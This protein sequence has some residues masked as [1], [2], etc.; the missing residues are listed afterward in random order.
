[1]KITRLRVVR[2]R[3]IEALDTRTVFK[4]DAIPAKGMIIRGANGGGKSSVL[5]AIRAAL[6]GQDIAADAIRLGADRADILLDLDDFTVKRAITAKGS[7]LSIDGADAALIRSPADWLATMIGAAAFDPIDLFKKKPKDR[8]AA[9]LGAIP[10]RVTAEELT[11]WLEGWVL[12]TPPDLGV[13]ALDVVEAARKDFY[14]RRGAENAKA[15]EIQREIDALVAGAPP[16]VPGALSQDEARARHAADYKAHGELVARRKRVEEHTA[17]TTRTRE[18]VAKLRATAA[19]ARAVAG[20]VDRS[21]ELAAEAAKAQ[22]EV[23]RIREKLQV[24]HDRE[25]NA[26]LATNRIGDERK[27]NEAALKA[28]AA[29]L[30]VVKAN[31]DQAA[32]LDAAVAAT[33]ETSPTD[34]EIAASHAAT[35]ESSHEVAKAT[36]AELRAEH[37]A[38][39]AET[40]RRLAGAHEAAGKLDAMVS[41]FTK[42]VPTELL[43]K[44]EGLRGLKLDGDSIF[45]DDVDLDKL[46]GREQILFAVEIARRLNARAKILIT[47]GLERVDADALPE[48]LKKAT[49]DGYQLIATRVEPGGVTF[50]AIELDEDSNGKDAG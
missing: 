27:A 43:A 37:E 49:A 47:D 32:E 21:A 42:A 36:A 44:A 39:L 23:D 48:F 28:H 22:T 12:T 31:E 33:A 17:R 18:H 38:R 3:G 11:K 9:I 41:K 15:K 19:E 30:A 8:R 2:Y 25:R 5:G 34:D 29:G 6:A 4:G 40:Q 16:A 45:L 24:L 14:A 13:H 26:I 10:M 50:E 35:V 46:S 1:M 20:P 7:R